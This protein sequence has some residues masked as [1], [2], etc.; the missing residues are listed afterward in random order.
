MSS[1]VDG[2]EVSDGEKPALQRRGDRQRQAILQAV[3]DLLGER[4]FSELSVASISARAGVGRS[5]FYFYFDSKYAVLAQLLDEIADHLEE[6]TDSFAAR[7]PGETPEQFA[8]RMV[9][10]A[11][12]VYCDTD[13]VVKACNAERY[14]DEAIQEILIRR[15]DRSVFQIVALIE[16]EV[17]AGTAQPISTDLPGLI[18]VLVGTTALILTRDPIMVA[19]GPDETAS[20]KLLE[21]IWFTS[22]WSGQPTH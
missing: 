1:Q 6:L 8:T 9:A 19:T 18:R 12:A 7:E 3:R 22:L 17:A 14:H 2:I 4:P 16:A 13:P 5:G 21:R 20:R 11:V 15:F 10:I